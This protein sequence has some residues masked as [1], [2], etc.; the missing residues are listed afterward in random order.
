MRNHSLLLVTLVSSTALLVPG[1][2]RADNADAVAG[3]FEV[4][5]EEVTSN[6]QDTGM[7][8][9]RGELEIAK[10]KGSQVAVDIARMPIMT[11]TANKGGRI[12]AASKLGKTSIQG[13]D[14]R[15]SVAGTVNNDGVLNVV[16][17]AEYYVSGKAYCTQSWNVSGFR[18]E[19][20]KPDAKAAPSDGGAETLAA[21]AASWSSIDLRRPAE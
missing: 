2:A 15:F 19:A 11:G 4:K 6:C 17:V 5:Y 14:G 3:T 1:T 12:K 13:L 10:R 8:L 16:F 21:P 18:K 20:T 9:S 7:V